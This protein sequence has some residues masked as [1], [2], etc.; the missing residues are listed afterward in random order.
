MGGLI[1]GRHTKHS[2][3]IDSKEDR[4]SVTSKLDAVLSARESRKSVNSLKNDDHLL[5]SPRQA[6]NETMEETLEP[7]S[8]DMEGTGDIVLDDEQIEEI[9]FPGDNEEQ[10]FQQLKET[11]KIAFSENG[12]AMTVATSAVE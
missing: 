4:K 10:F 7:R 8:P 5:T 1:N 6:I 3:F 2:K 9:S 11:N 12:D